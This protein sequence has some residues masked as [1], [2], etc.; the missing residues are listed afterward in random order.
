MEGQREAAKVRPRAQPVVPIQ[1]GFLFVDAAQ[2]KTSRQG[3]RNARS[4]VMQKARR[5]NPWST[6][7]HVAKQKKRPGSTSPNSAG[8]PDSQLHAT[9]PSPPVAMDETDYFLSSDHGPYSSFRGDLCPECQIFMCR[10]GQRMCPRCLLLKPVEDPSNS[11][12]DP[13]RTSSVEITAVVSELLEHCECDLVPT[14]RSSL[15]STRYRKPGTWDRNAA[16]I[17]G[18]RHAF[19]TPPKVLFIVDVG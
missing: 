11:S 3:R 2:A 16:I 17:L 15:P 14:S 19:C 8:T 7:K 6:S 18:E 1:Q 9:T 10:P 4:F 12:F 13:F 5:E